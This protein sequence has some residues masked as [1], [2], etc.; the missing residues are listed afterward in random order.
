MGEES[1]I[2]VILSI[3]LVERSVIV[4]VGGGGTE[5]RT[6]SLT[7][8]GIFITRVFNI[9][10]PRGIGSISDSSRWNTS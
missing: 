9:S 3:K 2:S 10:V 6:S 7:I 1:V 4:G 5:R 8:S